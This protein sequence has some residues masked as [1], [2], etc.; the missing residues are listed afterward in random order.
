M[1]LFLKSPLRLPFRH[2][3]A[4][5]PMA[6]PNVPTFIGKSNQE[7]RVLFVDSTGAVRENLGR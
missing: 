1:V 4:G 6:L 7:A 5:G 2:V 3:P